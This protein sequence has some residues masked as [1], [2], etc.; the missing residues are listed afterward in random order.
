MKMPLENTFTNENCMSFLPTL[1]EESVTLALYDP[2]YFTS[3]E[4]NFT[5]KKDGKTTRK[6]YTT[7]M[8]S[9]DKWETEEEFFQ[10]LKQLLV[11]TRR[12]L[13]PH[14]SLYLFCRDMYI[15]DIRRLLTETGY[16]FKNVITWIKRNPFQNIMQ[17]SYNSACE[18][19]VFA[20]KIEDKVLEG[21]QKI[22]KTPAV[23]NWF[24]QKKIFFPRDKFKKEPPYEITMHN[25]LFTPICMAPERI[26]DK[27]GEVLHKTQKPIEVLLRPILVSSNPGDL[28]LD[29]TAGTASTLEAA[30]LLKRRYLGSE[31]DKNFYDYG[32]QRLEGRL[33]K[34]KL[35]KRMD[36]IIKRLTEKKKTISLESFFD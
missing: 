15:S 26:I 34:Y 1:K 24:N 8:G 2:P 9:W 20:K 14:G 16:H 25:Y 22:K 31:I 13:I 28:V 12:V 23:F 27:T 35:S 3:T 36:F 18:L 11:E 21:K 19:Q 6:S 10:W 4:R 33:P 7:D 32:Q 17:S 30:R 5:F 29:A